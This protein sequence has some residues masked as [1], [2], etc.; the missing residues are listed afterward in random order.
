MVRFQQARFFV[1]AVAILA[2]A[3]PAFG[4]VSDADRNAARDLYTEGEGL[5]NQGKFSDALDRYT[6]SLQVFPAPTT[7]FRIA[8]CRAALGQLVEAAEE[9][10]VVATTPLQANPPE[11]FVKAKQDAAAELQ[12]LEPRI[13]KVRINVLPAGLQGLS[14]TIDN[15][16]MSTAL[17]GVPRAVNPGQHRIV[18]QAPG[19]QAAQSVV[20][21]RERQQPMPE[22]TLTLQP[23]GGPT[24]TVTQPP[25]PN[26]NVGMTYQGGGYVAPGTTYPGAYPYNT[27]VA[28]PRRPRGPSTA[29]WLGIDGAV[30]I[31]FDTAS[32]NESLNTA[33][34]TA[35]G[36]FGVD[37]GFRLARIIYLGAQVQGTYFGGDNM[38][39][40]SGNSFL[41]AAL[42]GLM[43]NPEG[44]GIFF[45]VGVGYR[46]FT[47]NS[48]K[49]GSF[50]AGSA[51]SLI[52]LGVQVKAGSFRF[53]PKID[54]GLGGGDPIPNNAVQGPLVGA[55]LFDLAIFWE[56][57][58]DKPVAVNAGVQTY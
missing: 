14:V 10:R 15:V 44:A 5:R 16:P 31:P 11:A 23:G 36:S 2:M 49:G 22:V 18:A 13:P 48:T 33:V 1:L 58:L 12:A 53:V 55:L 7:A 41:F 6:R 47:L 43:S 28:P 17:I 51:E 26:P 24:Y 50:G 30:T 21:V 29:L 37:A 4:Q 42:F 27:W 3:S 39:Y 25:P 52:G 20:D 40:T 19:Y 32:N 46:T 45:D 9:Y 8:Q 54:L 56:L 38:N 34:G 57:P 35:G